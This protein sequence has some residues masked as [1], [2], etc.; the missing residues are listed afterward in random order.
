MSDLDLKPIINQVVVNHLQGRIKHEDKEITATLEAPEELPKVSADHTRVLQVLTN[1][2]CNHCGNCATGC[3]HG[4]KASLDVT[5]L[6]EA[7]RQSGQF[8]IYTGSD[9]RQL[10]RHGPQ[11][12]EI[13][14]EHTDE[15]AKAT[16]GEQCSLRARHV[17]VAA[18]SYGSVSLLARSKDNLS[19]SSRLGHGFSGNGDMLSVA[20]DTR[21]SVNM[22]ATSGGPATIGKGPGPV[23]TGMVDLR[24]TEGVLIEEMSVPFPLKA[25]FEQV[26]STLA[27]LHGLQRWDGTR[28]SDGQAFVDPLAVSNDAMR[29]TAVYASM[30]D[31]G[32][33]GVMKLDDSGIVSWPGLRHHPLFARQSQ[34]IAELHRSSGVG[35]T[36]IDNPLWRPV[37]ESLEYLTNGERGPLLTVHPLGGC[38]MGNTPSTGVVNSLGQ[39]FRSDTANEVYEE[40]LVLDGSILPCAVGSNPAL[41]IAALARRAL[42]TLCEGTTRI[43][44]STES[45]QCWSFADVESSR[46]RRDPGRIEE[47]KETRETKETKETKEKIEQGPRLPP[48]PWYRFVENED[49]QPETTFTLRERLNGDIEIQGQRMVLELTIVSA[50][51]PVSR[52]IDG[53][54]AGFTLAKGSQARIYTPDTYRQ[55]M[56]D[57]VGGNDHYEAQLEAAAIEQSDLS[58]QVSVFGRASSRRVGRTARSLW[59]WLLNRG[60]RDTWQ[61]LADPRPGPGDGLGGRLSGMF[62]LASHAGEVRTMRYDLELGPGGCTYLPQ[63][64]SVRGSKYMVYERR[65]NPLRQMMQLWVEEF[66]GA[67]RFQAQRW[68]Q[69]QSEGVPRLALDVSYLA[70]IGVPLLEIHTQHDLVSSQIDIV[71]ILAYVVRMMINGFSWVFRAPDLPVIAPMRR[72]PGRL[73]GI[74]GFK[75]YQIDVKPGDDPAVVTRYPCSNGKP[76]V[77]FHG[78]SAS[79]TTFAHECLSPAFVTF[80]WRLGW[81]VWVVDFR[82]S[83]GLPSAVKPYSFEDIGECDVPIVMR[84]IYEQTGRPLNVLAH[85]MGAAMF[86]MS[87]L[88]GRLES[89]PIERAVLTQVGPGVV[90]SAANVF[91]AFALAVLKNYLPLD[92]YDFRVGAAD[93]LA[94]Q[95]LDR[96]LN[97]LPYPESEYDIEN[98]PWPPWKRTPFVGARHRMDAL[99]GRDFSLTNVSETFLHDIDAMFG[100]LNLETV[101]QV[102]HLSRWKNVTDRRGRNLYFHRSRLRKYWNF[103]TMSLHGAENGLSSPATLARNREMFEAAGCDYET[104]LLDGFG[105]QDIWVSPRSETE[106]FP[107]IAEYLARSSNPDQFDEA[108]DKRT[109]VHTR[110]GASDALLV[111][112]PFLGP[113]STRPDETGHVSIRLGHS[114]N[115][116]SPKGVLLVPGAGDGMGPVDIDWEAPDWDRELIWVGPMDYGL[117]TFGMLTIRAPA[118]LGGSLYVFLVYEEDDELTEVTFG[119]S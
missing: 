73:V 79:G 92:R 43:D 42:S 13:V 44:S 102:I 83:P 34:L 5:V 91:R 97:L 39:V 62:T 75:Q 119:D 71:R 94:L 80:M 22:I 19:L 49:Y 48:R 50:P 38:G 67:G 6:A 37:P 69:R 1:L 105:H 27:T 87:V 78:Y 95:L 90:F 26:Y 85:C 103:P 74:D 72:L 15:H 56:L 24:D 23:I 108:K 3:N 32:A 70:R 112:P 65:A 63:D 109:A 82:T 114:P 99:Y 66:P 106:V 89:I 64:A 2:V 117:D 46:H 25:L 9:V 45:P 55:L 113:F 21:E 96:L 77:L 60:L 28:H 111:K 41:T 110:S 118:T 76:L 12:W 17:I 93:G 104:C 88:G 16:L 98:P 11:D 52:L 100:P 57:D 36:V 115:L 116:P 33:E 53:S 101:S 84:H 4:A 47:A 20:F 30:G 58:G 81:D 61:Y 54:R 86:S 59:A 40:L 8:G 29:R 7:K 10:K 68:R 18:G 35:G 51:V 31:D 14:V 107:K